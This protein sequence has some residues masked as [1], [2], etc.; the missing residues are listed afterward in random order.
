MANKNTVAPES[1]LDNILGKSADE[2]I[3]WES[4]T[5]PSEG[6]YYGDKI[7]GGNIEVRAM[8]LG[9][10]KILATARLAQSGKSL[11]MI[12]DRCVKFPSDFNSLDLLVGDRMFLFF[13]LRGITYGNMYEFVAEC[14]H[15]DCNMTSTFEYD[16]NDLAR[17]IKKPV[18]SLGHEPFKIVLPYMSK[19]AGTEFWVKVRLMRGKDLKSLLANERFMKRVNSGAESIDNSIESNLKTLIVEAMGSSDRIKIEALVKK[20]HSQDTST[21]RQFIEEYSPTI[22]TNIDVVCPHCDKDLQIELPITESFF[23]LKKRR[24]TG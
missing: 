23:R 14:T 18:P 12:Y 2:I 7:P 17:T 22:D 20:L 3:P 4:C 16:L 24:D 13:Y 21:I 11:D 9:E 5:L 10:E 6:L 19:I 1:V 15:G 8:G